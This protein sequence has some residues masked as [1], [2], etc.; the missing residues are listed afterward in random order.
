MSVSLEPNDDLTGMLTG[1]ITVLGCAVAGFGAAAGLLGSA[2]FTGKVTVVDAADTDEV[3]ARAEII[4][5]L[6]GHTILGYTGGLPAGTQYLVVSPG[7]PLEHPMINEARVVGAEVLGEIELAWRLRGVCASREAPWLVV[8]GTNGKTTTTLM[9]H[10]ILT[11]A[12]LRSAAVGNIG[13][14]IVDTIMDPVAYDVLAVE[15]SAQQ[16]PFVST[17]S[18]TASV[19]LNLAADHLDYFATFEDYRAA[20]AVAY[21]R[22]QLAALWNVADPHT[23]QMLMDAEV[24]EG[25]RAIGVTLGVPSISMLGL[26]EEMLVDRAFLEERHSHANPL[27][28]RDDVVVPGDHNLFN[29]LAAAGLAR[30]IGVSPA[31]VAAGLRDFQPAAHR[32]AEV[33][34]ARGVT[35]ID[36]SKATNTH[37]V[38]ASLKAYDQVVWLAGGMAK[39]QDFNELVATHAHRLRAVVVLGVD[40]QLIAD[41]VV[42]VAPDVPI[43]LIDDVV[44]ESAMTAAV[45]AAAELA[46]NGDVVLL[47]PGCSSWDLFAGGYAQRGDAFASAVQQRLRETS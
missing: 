11:A 27:A 4:S 21:E 18:P 31:A 38:D 47:A 3:R 28:H 44:G 20:K 39:G 34:T 1:H 2:A 42:S 15:V 25:C 37:A 14:S 16:L 43:V 46:H 36:D 13:T 33:A 7:V 41:A 26:V 40:R 29:A 12:G 6:G 23:E 19:V 35:W 24:V 8:T 17:M 30:A 45:G 22:T 10:S 9:L 5:A 32:V